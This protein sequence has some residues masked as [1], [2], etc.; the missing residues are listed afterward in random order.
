MAYGMGA[1]YL[2]PDLVVTKDGALI[3]LHDITLERTTN[4]KEAFPERC[5]IRQDGGGKLMLHWYAAD[6]I[7]AEIKSLK[8][9]ERLPFRFRQ[10][11]QG[12]QIPTFEELIQMVL[13]LNR[14]TGRSVG[15]YPETKAP[16]F[17][18]SKGLSME[19]PLLELLRKY[20]Y[21]GPAARVFIQSFDPAHLKKMRFEFASNLPMVQLISES[22]GPADSHDWLIT[23]EGLDEIATYANG[24]GPNKRRIEDEK[25][26]PVND[27]ALVQGAHALGLLV[28]PYTFRAEA[29]YLPA[30]DQNLEQELH[31][32][33]FEYGVDGVFT[34]HAD[35]AVRIAAKTMM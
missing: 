10:D 24:I 26:R 23:D 2:E 29:R 33:F 16:A 12:F 4:V 25:G 21:P 31:R 9:Q 17:H 11:S 22:N 28:H 35:K 15:I 7:L 34:D 30:R 27:N 8:V 18:H 14:L 32:F 20:G 19:R 3:C 5:R 6:F 1:D 13:E